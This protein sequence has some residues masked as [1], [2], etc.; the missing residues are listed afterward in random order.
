[1]SI[2]ITRFKRLISPLLFELPDRRKNPE[3]PQLQLYELLTS[4][5]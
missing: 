3:S 5:R 2:Q 4:K 1:M